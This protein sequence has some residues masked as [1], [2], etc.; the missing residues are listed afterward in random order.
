MKRFALLALIAPLAFT[1]CLE[2]SET[3]NQVASD[4]TLSGRQ[5][6]RSF[7]PTPIGVCGADP[8]LLVACTNDFAVACN[9]GGG[10]VFPGVPIV[11]NCAD[12]SKLFHACDP[13]FKQD[14]KSLDGDFGCDNPD[15]TQGHCTIPDSK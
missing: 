12:N 8:N 4:L 5:C 7:Q 11:I 6:R 15:C 3:Q 13:T 9:A 10:T 14:C 2:A 1:G